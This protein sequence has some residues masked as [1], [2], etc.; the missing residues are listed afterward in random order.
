MARPRKFDE[1]T[2]MRSV[3]DQFGRAGYAATSVDDLGVVTGLG[4]GS[5]Y[6]AFGDKHS[7][8]VR[9]LDEYCDEVFGA[10]ASELL[11]GAAP[12]YDRLATFLRG[13][14]AGHAD[15]RGCLIARSAAERGSVDQ[16]VAQRTGRALTALHSALTGC[17]AQA[18]RDGSLDPA[19]DP[20]GLASLVLAVVRGVE[21]LGTGNAAPEIVLQAAEQTLALLPRSVLPSTEKEPP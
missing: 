13:R 18:Q 9:A 11:H 17:I 20:A 3:R 21:A 15:R 5:L 19:A 1:T 7:L 16:D 12:A 10:A 4:K 2:V 8:F 14:A 6:G